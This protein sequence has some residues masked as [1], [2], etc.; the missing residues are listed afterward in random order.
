[1]LDS[2]ANEQTIGAYRLEDEIAADNAG[3]VYRA[4]HL[5]TAQPV[6]I[7]ILPPDI[8]AA[9][10]FRERFER[11]IRAVAALYH[12][13][14]A[15][16]Y[17]FG[18]G[19]GRA[20]IIGELPSDGFLRDA[21]RRRT[22]T[23]RLSVELARQAAVGLS[24]AHA[25]GVVHG[26]L[27]PEACALFAGPGGSYLLK[28]GDFG[29]ARL[30]APAAAS[31]AV[32][33]APEQ[34]AGGGPDPS[35]DCYALGAIL[36]EMI[37][38]SPPPLTAI[39]LLR[40]VRPDAPADLEALVAR[41]LASTPSDRFN[42]M[43]ELAE[44]LDALV[45]AMGERLS[46]A[47]ADET[48][49][50]EQRSVADDA[51]VAAH[52]FTPAPED[53][54]LIA[55]V[56]AEA[57]EGATVIEARAAE[58]GEGATVIEAVTAEAD[59]G[60]TVIEA[61]AAEADE[62]ATVIE[63]GAAEADEGATVIEAGAAEADEGATVIEAGAAEADEGATVIA[64]VAAEA[65][66]APSSAVADATAALIAD[67]TP[68]E[69]LTVLPAPSVAPPQPSAGG[70][71]AAEAPSVVPPDEAVTILPESVPAISTPLPQVSATQSLIIATPPPGFPALPPPSSMPQVQLLDN[72]GAPLRVLSLTGDGLAIGRA[73]SNDLPLPDE[74]V[75][76]EH[77]FI[78][79]DGRQ[80]TITDL[81]SKNGTF[82]AG[83]RL[84]PQERYPWQ[85]GAP[86]RI[87]VYWLRLIPPLAQAAS[88]VA[89][90]VYGVPSPEAVAAPP[91]AVGALPPRAP[92]PV[93]PSFG[94]P[95]IP[96]TAA[97]PPQAGIT[98]MPAPG[99]PRSVPLPPQ[100]PLQPP[101][102]TPAGEV[103]VTQPP[104]SSNR[105]AVELE[106]DVM[107][108]TPGMPAVLRMT[109]HNY[110]DSV[111]HLRVDVQGVPETWIQGPTP[112]PQLLPNG[113]APVA[114]NINVPRTPE[115]RAG[116]YPVTIYARSRSRPNE[117]G[118]AQ[119]TW[120]VQAFIEHRLELKPRRA[121]GWRKAHYNLTL[122]NAG[123][124]PMRYTLIGEDDEQALSFN[125]GEAPVALEPGA[126]YKHRLTV[127]GPI[128]WLGSSQP[129]SFSVQARTEKRSDTQTSS[130]QFIQRAL[131]PTWLIPLALL[132]FLAILYF[133]TLPPVI[134]NPRF[135]RSPQIAGQPVRLIYEIDN[136]QRVELL[137]LGV[138]APA[139]SGR[140]T[141]E[142]LDATA[143]PPDL[144]IL[145]ISRFGVRA[146]AS[147]VVAVV[148]PTPTPAPTA[149]PPPPTAQ[150]TPE[151]LPAPTAAAAPPAPPP[152]PPPAL[153]PA[154]TP[155]PEV[156]LAE[157]LRLECRS[158]ERI[159]LTGIGPPR[160]S[161]LLYFGRRAVSGGSV[162]PN[163]VYQIDMLVGPERPGEYP[164]SV[165]LR[166]SDRPL[167]IRTY[168][169]GADRLVNLSSVAPTAV[170]TE[171]LCVVQR[172]EPTPT[173]AP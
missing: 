150:P 38:G 31:P 172:A 173:V 20:F 144:S 18:I 7:R 160:E 55:P 44:A 134:R 166:L 36:Y 22:L 41:C 19:E 98:Q 46:V 61:G 147:V 1:M 3:V 33:Q 101:G 11:E 158:G 132:A 125:V 137:P 153:P 126:A 37:V 30:I 76:E 45:A 2:A 6:A 167:P 47:A 69:A 35:T 135:E 5:P 159:V 63:A 85:G 86:V 127:R 4:R 25:R 169:Y 157:L 106:Q 142:F 48:T 104:L 51:T 165:R 95:A 171:I 68:D 23:L 124:V 168:Q 66:G 93:T 58:A 108:L 15:E 99:T 163:G 8:V 123:N 82:V 145:A 64:P 34:R 52:L 131:I 40:M 138:P 128:R 122:T 140:R 91:Q 74:S 67:T 133:V 100:A 170:T 77:A 62:G 146:E 116:P 96:P 54:T 24:A 59:E 148:T 72:A 88:V 56:A 28:I 78:D 119:A 161:F 29:I 164:V 65:E 107:T 39:P 14:I 110:S 87:G 130:A 97:A 156:S 17:E 16:L 92:A 81:G 152:A 79:W 53:A 83:V 112:E 90:A 12:P 115:S 121:A 89:P 32:Y 13:H 94:A 9:P 154:A 155:T 75:S 111:D 118:A 71:V 57:G 70:D 114:L 10:D 151:V 49:V 73:E 103:G 102:G 162:A 43:S 120:N 84:P 143:I 105:Y 113:R 136:A 42:R 117:A 141:F 109:L 60:A 27:K 21:I 80:V 50:I 129:R 26:A 149:T 139:E